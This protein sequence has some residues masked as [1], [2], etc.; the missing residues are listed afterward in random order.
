MSDS[1]QV[2]EGYQITAQVVYGHTDFDADEMTVVWQAINVENECH[3]CAG[4]H[5]HRED[6]EGIR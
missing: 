1:P 4:P 6:D 3:Y 2:L 5:R